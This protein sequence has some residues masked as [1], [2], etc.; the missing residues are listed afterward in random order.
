MSSRGLRRR[1]CARTS[2]ARGPASR[3]LGSR[4]VSERWGT[5]AVAASLHFHDGGCRGAAKKTQCSTARDANGEGG[6]SSIN[7]HH[8]TAAPSFLIAGIRA[9]AACHECVHWQR[10]RPRA[11]HCPEPPGRRPTNHAATSGLESGQSRCTAPASVHQQ[12]RMHAGFGVATRRAGTAHTRGRRD[13]HASTRRRTAQIST[14]RDRRSGNAATQRPRT[15]PTSRSRAASQIFA[16]QA[17]ALTR[18]RTSD[19]ASRANSHPPAGL[20]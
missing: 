16:T 9:G 2:A 20:P 14:R 12:S 7:S 18:A 5:C 6:L 1:L 3:K 19:A 10:R 15:Y 17:R 11:R 8:E 4:R 13:N